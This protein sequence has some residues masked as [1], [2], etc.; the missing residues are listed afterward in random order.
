MANAEPNMAHRSR[1]ARPAH[2]QCPERD[3]RE[4]KHWMHSHNIHVACIVLQSLPP[5]TRA[6]IP[7]QLETMPE[8]TANDLRSVGSNLY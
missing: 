8:I 5:D 2:W 1:E 4:K 6:C 7:V 3:G